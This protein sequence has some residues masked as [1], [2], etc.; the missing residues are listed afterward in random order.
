MT[1]AVLTD[2][3]K[4]ADRTAELSPRLKAR[5]AGVFYLITFVAGAF[6]LVVLSK[7][8]VRGDAA[9]TAHNILASEP[10]YRLAFAAELL[11][12]IS[13]VAVTLLLY[14]LLKPVNR[15]LSMLAVFFSLVGIATGA[16]ISLAHL[17]PLVVLAPAHYLAA[18]DTGQLQAMAL[19]SF[20]LHAQGSTIS[21][22][23]FGF[24]C[25]LIGYLIFRST[26]LPRTVGVLMMIAG[27]GWLT[28]SFASFVSPA[29]AHYLSAYNLG[30]VPGAIGEA[31]L[32]LWL[33]VMGVN[34][35]KWAEKANLLPS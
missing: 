25:F 9:A 23:F 35:A 8:V 7:L 11:A 15:S 6:D 16:L 13:Y 12:G 33:L 4:A 29:L 5:L 24:Y 14:E 18:F 17:V 27:L 22:V 21:I 30:L 3:S 1:A 31:S 34:A 19:M 2:G 32:M 20:T 28:N 26:F 10:S